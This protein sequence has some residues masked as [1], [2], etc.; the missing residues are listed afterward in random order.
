MTV[1][2]L[3]VGIVG[4]GIGGLTL[5]HALR[6]RGIGVTVFERDSGPEATAG[7]RLHLPAT[8]FTAL[9]EVLPAAS[10]HA[11]R[12]CGAGN[13]GFRQFAVLDHRGR[14]R[15][16]IPIEHAGET[17]LIGRR[18]LRAVLARGLGDVIRWN[19]T[20]TGWTASPDGVELADGSRFDLL[21]A[22]DGTGSRTARRLLGRTTARRSGFIGIAGRSPLPQRIPADLR[23]GLAFMV[24]PGGVGVFLSLHG[25]QGRD[26]AAEHP[27]VVWSI[28]ARLADT[29][30][31]TDRTGSPPHR[32][33]ERRLPQAHR[34][35]GAGQRGRVPLPLPGRAGAL[36]Q[37]P[38]HSPRR[39][40]PPD[41]AD[42]GG[43]GGHRHPGRGAPC[44]GPGHTSGAGS[45]GSVSDEVADLCP[46][47]GRRGAAGADLAAAAGESD[48]VR[49][50]RA[51]GT[52][53]GGRRHPPGQ[54]GTAVVSRP[55]A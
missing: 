29:D 50:R 1:D 44:G 42:R 45:A 23:R 2:A 40:R 15:L 7:Y 10:V 24:G 13:D 27:Y 39:R 55:E 26:P 48:V 12:D 46:G 28:S 31:D 49:P 18:P 16:R 43:R 38:G 6:R 4:A 17:L 37:R 52:A 14:V 53:G 3:R 30:T 25:E 32:G 36:A 5:A 11:L 34:P 47:G 54:K 9:T 8:A 21:V 22:A 20:V 35:L 19:T 41:A 33:L 51:A